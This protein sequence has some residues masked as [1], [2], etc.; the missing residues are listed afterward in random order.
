MALCSCKICSDRIESGGTCTC[1]LK[2]FYGKCTM[3]YAMMHAVSRLMM[4]IEALLTFVNNKI[5]ALFLE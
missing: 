1:V 4:S 5:C 2:F 3:A